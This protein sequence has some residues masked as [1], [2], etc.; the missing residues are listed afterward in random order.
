ML[1][2]AVALARVVPSAHTTAGRTV[3][4]LVFG[5]L[6][7]VFAAGWIVTIPRPGRLEITSAGIRYMPGNGQVSTL[8]RN[9]GDT[10]RW[11]KQL[12]GRIWKLGLTIEGTNTVMVLGVFS[13]KAVQQACLA[14]GW[15]FG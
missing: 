3:G 4:A 2:S 10:L 1:A 7:V 13:R 8:S 11:V 9:Q 6:L 12:H 15:R 5:V 14:R